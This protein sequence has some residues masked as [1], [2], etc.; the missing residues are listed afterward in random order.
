GARSAICG[1]S[2]ARLKK[3][4]SKPWSMP[5]ADLR[6]GVSTLERHAVGTHLAGAGNRAARRPAGDEEHVDA[7]RA[8]RRGAAGD[9]ARRRDLRVGVAR[10]AGALYRAGRS[11]SALDT[12]PRPG[13]I[14]QPARLPPGDLD[15][16][17]QLFPADGVAAVDDLNSARG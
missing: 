12:D 11:V 1:R 10:A 2:G 16:L 8:P 3:Y 5:D 7:D 17:L 6:P 15:D 13:D 9:R 14:E 4:S